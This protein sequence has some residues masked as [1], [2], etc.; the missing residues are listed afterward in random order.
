MVLVLP[1]PQAQPSF[2]LIAVFC[3]RSI[4]MKSEESATQGVK[5]IASSPNF[6]HHG[7]AGRSWHQDIQQTI[8][9]IHSF[10]CQHSSG[11]TTEVLQCAKWT[12][13]SIWTVPLP[14]LPIA[15]TWKCPL[16]PHRDILNL[17]AA[18]STFFFVSFF[19]NETPG[20]KNTRYKH[21]NS[22]IANTI[23]GIQK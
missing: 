13:L 7:D 22:K 11:T 21:P 9:L 18:S 3:T 8:G 23:K 20:I 14:S 2:T 5:C 6:L 4:L 19:F 15:T 17:S 12:F 10:S 16:L 1:C